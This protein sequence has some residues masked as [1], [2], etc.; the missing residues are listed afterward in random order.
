[1]KC[2]TLL[3]D[4]GLRDGNVGVMKGVIWNIAPETQ[5]ADL[6]HTIEPQNVLM[7]ALILGRS[8]PYFPQNSVHIAVVDP[9]VGTTRRPIAAHL[10]DRYFVGPDNGLLTP[11]LERAEKAGW[12]VEVVHLNRK[13]YWLKDISYVF[14]GRDI[15]SPVAAHIANGIALKDLGE[16]IQDPVRLDIPKPVWTGD[17][18]LGRIMHIDYFG[19]VATNIRRE[20]M[21]NKDLCITIAG[22]ELCGL[23]NT[24]GEKEPGELVVLYG[25][26][27][28]LIVSVVN[29]DA[30]SLLGVK[31]GDP[32]EVRPV[33]KR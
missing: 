28:D 18:L 23:V 16:V 17:A 29:G 27:G 11:L 20:D 3:T 9:G 19:N 21:S 14:H 33:E 4:F 1:M 2:I 6:S 26:T 7:G 5:I 24:F 25:S 13:K 31:I 10:G 32:V 22:Q 30:A 12:P 8:C 15:F